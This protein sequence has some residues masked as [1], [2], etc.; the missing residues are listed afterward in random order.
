MKPLLTMLLIAAVAGVIVYEFSPGVKAQVDQAVN[1]HVGWT[2]EARKADPKG[3]IEHAIESLKEDR[4][5]FKAQQ[6]AYAQI[7]QDA[8]AGLATAEAKVAKAEEVSMAAKAT[9]QTA[10]AG[11]AWPVSFGNLNYSREQL[12]GQVQTVLYEK[13]AHS[14]T[15]G[16]YQQ[17][18]DDIDA[19]GLALGS[20]ITEIGIEIT[21][22]KA[23]AQRAEMMKL[24]ADAEAMLAKVYDLLEGNSDTLV[25]LH[26]SPIRSLDEI[27]LNEE[28][29]AE[30]KAATVANKDVMDFLEGL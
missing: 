19:Q 12:V 10:E 27:D 8:V 9:F 13:K 20:R 30:K 2:P 26:D 5:A 21:K 22:L 14:E 25:E 24:N 6:L 11:N 16:I 29:T 23:E 28:P 17:T 15:I 4:A 18:I 3:F 7:R 1:K